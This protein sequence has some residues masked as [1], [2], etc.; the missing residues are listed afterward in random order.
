MAVAKARKKPRRRASKSQRI[1]AVNAQHGVLAALVPVGLLALAIA[2]H[3]PWESLS[4]A[5][6][7]ALIG[8]LTGYGLR[9]YNP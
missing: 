9:R 2:G 6:C 1:T 7:L 8:N 4:D 5:V 3:I